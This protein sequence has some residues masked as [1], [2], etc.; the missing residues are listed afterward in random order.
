M[1]ELKCFLE[2]NFPAIDFDSPDLVGRGALDSL[3]LASLIMLLEEK[4]DIEIGMEYISPERFESV[5]AIW[6]L[7]EELR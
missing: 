1:N 4:Y 6:D 7:V 2:E 3:A 5:A